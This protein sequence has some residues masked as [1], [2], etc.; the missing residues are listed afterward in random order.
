[1][2]LYQSQRDICLNSLVPDL[3]SCWFCYGHSVPTA[4]PMRVLAFPHYRAFAF[5]VC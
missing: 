1:M 4:I 3:G 2:A 5:S